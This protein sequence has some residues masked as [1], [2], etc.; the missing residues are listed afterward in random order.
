[1]IILISDK[2]DQ[3]KYTRMFKTSLFIIGKK[4]ENPHDH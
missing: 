3:M 1:M 4:L 2:V